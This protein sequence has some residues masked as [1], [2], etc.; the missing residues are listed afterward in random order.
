MRRGVAVV[1]L[2]LGVAL[3][4]APLVLPG[5]GVDVTALMDPAQGRAAPV[6]QPEPG[7]AG[8]EARMSEVCRKINA[9]AEG[10]AVDCS[11]LAMPSAAPGTAAGTGAA[12]TT[13]VRVENTKPPRRKDGAKFV[14]VEEPA[15]P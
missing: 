6:P 2:T 12:A 9:S 13:I 11:E 3:A 14:R 7:A 10:A 8:P 4:S 15:A 5:L 1:I